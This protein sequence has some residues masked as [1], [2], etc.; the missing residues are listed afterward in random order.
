VCIKMSQWNSH[1]KWNSHENLIK[2]EEE[3]GNK[4]GRGLNMIK[5]F[6]MNLLKYQ[7]E[8][9][10]FVQLKNADKKRMCVNATVEV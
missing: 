8:T 2:I 1:E 5:I 7:N 10:Y 3:R 6:Y 4:Y 9:Y